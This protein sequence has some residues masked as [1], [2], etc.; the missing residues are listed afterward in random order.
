MPRTRPPYPNEFRREAVELVRGV[1]RSIPDVARD[2]GC[3]A[4]TLRNW[5]R[6]DQIEAGE[7]EGLTSEERDE[8]R[9]L[10][11]RVRTLELEKEVLRKAT[12]FFAR[13]SES[14]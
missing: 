11:K 9:H 4:Q 14:R 2:L 3:S 10:R 12:A 7:R 1:G 5:V 13:E 6:Q 8:L